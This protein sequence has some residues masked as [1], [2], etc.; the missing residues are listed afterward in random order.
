MIEFIA[1]VDEEDL[2]GVDPEAAEIIRNSRFVRCADCKYSYLF[3][4]WESGSAR[5]CDMLRSKWAKDSDLSVNDDDYCSGGLRN[6]T[7]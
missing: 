4:P 3:E 5:Y 1:K 2:D 7:E 6:D